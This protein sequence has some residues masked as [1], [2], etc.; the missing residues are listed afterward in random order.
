MWLSPMRSVNERPPVPAC[1]RTIPVSLPRSRI[2]AWP[3]LWLWLLFLAAGGTTSAPAAPT[4][5][6]TADWQQEPETFREESA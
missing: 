1:E 4:A 5:T 3:S 2:L 6:V